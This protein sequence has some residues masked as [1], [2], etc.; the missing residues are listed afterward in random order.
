MKPKKYPAKFFRELV[1]TTFA[2]GFD[3]IAKKYGWERKLELMKLYPAGLDTK[4]V[5]EEFLKSPTLAGAKGKRPFSDLI[6]EFCAWSYAAANYF[7]R[8]KSQANALTVEERSQL[9]E[10]I[11]YYLHA[12]MGFLEEIFIKLGD[13]L[14]ERSIPTMLVA[15]CDMSVCHLLWSAY[16]RPSYVLSP[17]L[18]EMLKYTKLDQYPLEGLR[19]PYPTLVLAPP[20]SVM[21]E[22]FGKPGCLFVG[23]MFNATEG[24]LYWNI[25]AL[26]SD[27]GSTPIGSFCVSKPGLTV[28]EAINES[29]AS[30]IELWEEYQKAQEQKEFRV[31]ANFTGPNP[32]EQV[33]DLF[34]FVCAA[35]VYAT[36][37][38]AD[39]ILASDS[40]IYKSWIE[41]LGHHHYTSRE[42]KEN[43]QA[44]SIGGSRRFYLGRQI[45]IIDR[46][47]PQEKDAAEDRVGRMSPR[48]HWRSGHF[49]RVWHG[50]EGE[51]FA[52]TQWIKPTLVGLPSSGNNLERR[53]G[54]R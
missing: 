15:T 50:S 52:V 1:K 53:A 2:D 4:T 33:K 29:Y 9:L 32:K 25:R 3:P 34:L 38:D 46:H 51:K 19:L 11:M 26:Y 20:D 17:D 31:V 27:T 45:K 54:M 28:E 24:Q 7:V 36:M 13:G 40:P 37:P 8:D 44:Q 39:I 18:A 35:M 48:L 14:D 10:H 6:S 22:L 21:I 42:R 16:N 41:S 43:L 49:R 23:E 30:L 5:A 47:D 12:T